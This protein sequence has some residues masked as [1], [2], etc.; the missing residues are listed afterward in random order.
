MVRN[1]Q[2]K[3]V[4]ALF[5]VMNAIEQYYSTTQ[6]IK[7]L[8]LFILPVSGTAK[9]LSNLHLDTRRVIFVLP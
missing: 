6:T 9:C 2:L 1:D 3:N 7:L 5:I 4:S 8:T